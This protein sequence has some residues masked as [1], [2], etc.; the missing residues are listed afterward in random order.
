MKLNF[1]EKMTFYRETNRS[2][3]ME[4]NLGVGGEDFW[5]VEDDDVAY[6]SDTW[7]HQRG[8]V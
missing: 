3:E 6:N 4:V 1:L 7:R 2:S 8:S 5:E